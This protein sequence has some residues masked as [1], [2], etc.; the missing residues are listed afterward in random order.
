MTTNEIYNDLTSPRFFKQPLLPYV[1]IIIE[2]A[3]S[4]ICVGET[5]ITLDTYNHF[6]NEDGDEC[7]KD[8]NLTFTSYVANIDVNI[9]LTEEY[10]IINP[11]WK[12]TEWLDDNNV[13]HIDIYIVKDNVKEKK[14]Y[15]DS[16]LTFNV[17]L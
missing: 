17:I 8:M 7:F 15:I 12:E 14:S 6:K 11:D 4:D 2:Q 13:K 9:H 1:I 3:V 5:Y 16:N 10:P